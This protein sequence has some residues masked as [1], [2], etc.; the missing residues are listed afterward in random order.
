MARDTF[1]TMVI[2][3]KGP[4]GYTVANRR[5]AIKFVLQLTELSDSPFKPAII[6]AQEI[7]GHKHID[8]NLGLS[9]NGY[10][11]NSSGLTDQAGVIWKA[12]V[13]TEVAP[14]IDSGFKAKVDS[15]FPINTIPAELKGRLS[16][17]V[18]QGKNVPGTVYNIL[19]V[20]WHGPH[21]K[22]STAK[23]NWFQSLQKYVNKMAEMIESTGVPI[24]SI[25]I[26]GDYNLAFTVPL[27][28]HYL[29]PE[30]DF[31]DYTMAW[32]RVS[33]GKKLI[34]NILYTKNKTSITK[35]QPMIFQNMIG[36]SWRDRGVS[37][38]PRWVVELNG[39]VNNIAALD[40]DPIMAQIVVKLN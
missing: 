3:M 28:F 37:A 39:G 4:N 25:L 17:V 15:E 9:D 29:Q 32:R 40:H 34:D 13:F 14:V 12:D 38:D 33:K 16:A 19:A 20:S 31:K 7:E 22:S 36:P 30:F 8:T 26:G 1:D 11:Y 2:N 6:F 23:K 35:I 24:T 21:K 10:Q 18:L 27:R 5:D